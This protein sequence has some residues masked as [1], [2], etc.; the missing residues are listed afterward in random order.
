[1]LRAARGATGKLAV[2]GVAPDLAAAAGGARWRWQARPAPFLDLDA[3]RAAGGD[4]LAALSANTRQ[5]I[6][7]AERRAGAPLVL[8]VATTPEA[9][10]GFLDEMIPLHERRWEG[11]GAFSTPWLARFHATL[12][13]RLAARGE[14]E[15]LRVTAGGRRLGLLEN[16]RRAGVVHA[17]QSGFV[18]TA[19]DAALKPG[20]LCHL[21]AIRRA[22]AEGCVEYD[23]MAGEQRYKRS[24]AR[25]SRDLVWAEL[26]PHA[27]WRG[28]AATLR[29]AGASLT[30]ALA[31]ARGERGATQQD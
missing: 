5:Q 13:A 17:Y 26:V 14:V 15:M 12:V 25:E 27:S 8:E 9:A 19:G 2:G 28:V 22:L 11:Q 6:R 3:L 18:D 21:L 24:L 20:L 1:M 29:G 7:R 23:L 4:V 31:N 16:F 30:A 10:A